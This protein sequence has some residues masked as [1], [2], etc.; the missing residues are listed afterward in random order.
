MGVGDGQQIVVYD[1][2]GLFSA[3]RLWWNFRLMGKQDVA[4][5]DGGLPKWLA[6][7]RPTSSEPPVIR[8]RHLTAERQPQL[9]RDITQVA[10]AAK[11]GLA[12][13]VD[14]RAAARFA[15]DQPEPRAGL[16]SGHIPG[17]RN[18]P[19]GEVLNADGTMKSPEALREV[20]TKAGVDLSRPIIT[21][22][23][24]GV[25]AAILALA[26]ERLGHRDWSLYDGSWSEWGLSDDLPV[27]TGP[28]QP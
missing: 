4:V 20:F 12:Q 13:V 25:T 17:A 14:A 7:G 9:V 23:G 1:G 8:D 10:Q 19:F 24:S 5:L 2:A 16:R 18:V 22:C 15:G 27:E 26:L 6:E 28:A 11:L 3:A 21:S